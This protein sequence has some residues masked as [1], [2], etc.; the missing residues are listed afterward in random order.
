MNLVKIGHSWSQIFEHINIVP[1][2]KKALFLHFWEANDLCLNGVDVKTA[3]HACIIW[4]G[5]VLELHKSYANPAVDWF[6]YN[7]KSCD[8]STNLAF[9]ILL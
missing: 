6:H 1:D 2:D 3:S 8:L 4:S 9:N 5:N 7:S